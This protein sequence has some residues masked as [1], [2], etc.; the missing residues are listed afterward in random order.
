VCACACVRVT[1]CV[2]HCDVFQDEL[3]ALR[4]ENARLRQL[5]H[6]PAGGGTLALTAP[7]PSLS[8]A[9]QPDEQTDETDETDDEAVAEDRQPPSSPLN[10]SVG[11]RSPASKSL[12]SAAITPV[13]SDATEVRPPATAAE[14]SPLQERN[15]SFQPPTPS[16]VSAARQSPAPAEGTPPSARSARSAGRVGASRGANRVGP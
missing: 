13:A 8:P 5:P 4:A 12:T 1:V 16:P 7:S 6:S 3:Q 9:L 2:C 10:R 11:A 14:R 15:A